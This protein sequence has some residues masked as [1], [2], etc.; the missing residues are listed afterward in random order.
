[1]GA[2]YFLMAQLPSLVYEQGL[3]MS[4][5][6]FKSLARELM[7]AGDAKLLD[8]CT[9][10]PEPLYDTRG[11]TQSAAADKTKA[12]YSEPA[13]ET[14]S[15]FINRWK[16]WERALR[17]NLARGRAQKLKREL[18]DAPVFPETAVAAAK[19]AM[20]IDSPLEAEIFLDNARWN[21]ISS[22]AGFDVFSESAAYA[23]LLKLLLMERRIAFNAEEGSIEYQGLYAAILGFPAPGE[24]K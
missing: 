16:E 6:A 14:S 10:D 7:S 21:A 24:H 11:E 17:L 23:Y 4:S 8:F 22:F 19:T 3:P 20:A 12:A 18:H 2:Y 9:L 13:K 5:A 1:M 15:A